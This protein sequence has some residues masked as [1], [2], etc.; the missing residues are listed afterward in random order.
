MS[1]RHAIL[2]IG[3]LI[4]LG[5]AG[6]FGVNAL[7]V[8]Q[9]VAGINQS[10]AK[11]PAGVAVKYAAI[12]YSLIDDKV[13]V[14]GLSVV[15]SARYGNFALAV[16]R[17]DI[18]H[19]A[20]GFADD[21]ARLSA[22]PAAVTPDKVMP[23]ADEIDFSGVRIATARTVAALE[24]GQIK[25]VRLHPW[26]LLRPEV[27]GWVAETRALPLSVAMLGSKPKPA[28]MLTLLSPFL[29]LCA[30]GILAVD[31]DQLTERQLSETAHVDAGPAAGAMDIAFSVDQATQPAGFHQ[32]LVGPNL[33]TGIEESA[34][35]RF[36]V[37]IAQ[38]NIGTSDVRDAAMKLVA[39]APLSPDLL[40]NLKI[41]GLTATGIAAQTALGGTVSIGDIGFDSFG[42]DQGLPDA[43]HMAIDELRLTDADLAINARAAGAMR[44][45]GLHSL[46]VSMG[47]GYRWNLDQ[48][49]LV[50]DRTLFKID[51][52]GSV[53]LD[54]NLGGVALSRD[55]SSFS[56]ATVLDQ[57]T[58][59]Y[60][61]ASLANR[62]LSATAALRG[63][64][65]ET[66]RLSLIAM[67]QSRGAILGDSPAATAIPTA[68]AGFVQSPGAL[69]MSATPST[70]VKL[71]D[72]AGLQALSPADIVRLLGL[73]V[74]NNP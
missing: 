25:G 53:T 29:R 62:L 74:T 63:I 17:L 67:I 48:K 58:L 49:S 19:G 22:D 6:Y 2:A 36:D 12:S 56:N 5:V 16:D 26:S 31:Y 69:T 23:I 20:T 9:V 24:S 13:R 59:R 72:L 27:P 32:G 38:L 73:T 21:W 71:A 64:D 30:A 66:L 1:L 41:S 40:D 18:L 8:R 44:M 3:A 4:V 7:I 10:I 45:L 70:P 33:Q 37:K 60:R 54:A 11:L 47:I 57:V 52:L 65:P 15:T 55:V 42:F 28:Q 61:D 34:H 51:E 35:G 39:G 14:T 50:L 43:A 46:T 68:L